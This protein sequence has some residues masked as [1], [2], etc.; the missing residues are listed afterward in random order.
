MPRQGKAPRAEEGG[1]SGNLAEILLYSG[2]LMSNPFDR[3]MRVRDSSGKQRG[4]SKQ[5]AT[6]LIEERVSSTAGAN[7]QP[8]ASTRAT[9]DGGVSA[10]ANLLLTTR[11]QE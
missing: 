8:A 4:K 3:A 11:T 2:T 6:V 7:L 10:L 9:S 5:I 1:G